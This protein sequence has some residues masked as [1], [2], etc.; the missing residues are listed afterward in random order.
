MFSPESFPTR[1]EA[2]HAAADDLSDL[3]NIQTGRHVLFLLSG[4]SALEPLSL[5]SPGVF[6]ADT[7]VTVLDDRF[8]PDPES[9]NYLQFRHM[10]IYG[11]IEKT[12]CE[13]FPTDPRQGETLTA[14]A[15]RLDGNLRQWVTAH[16]DGVVI[17]LMGIG[18]DGHTAGIMRYPEDPEF[19]RK[20]FVET[21][22]M[23][24][25]YDA[26]GKNP[27]PLRAT[28]TIPFLRDFVDAAVVTVFGQEKIP[29]LR[30]LQ[31]SSGTLSETPA[32][33]IREMKQATIFTD[34]DIPV[35]ENEQ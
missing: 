5:L 2:A 11:Q 22:R 30:R 7:T 33:I 19:F 16:P 10:P 25:G 28:V 9:N 35:S 8:S 27:Y 20:T 14:F 12:G 18:T 13:F 24:V 4:G 23:V 3:I 32:R 1:S 15:D 26:T 6:S 17:A 34:L 21:D 29:A 31:S